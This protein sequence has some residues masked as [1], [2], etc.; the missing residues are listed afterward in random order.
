M[1]NEVMNGGRSVARGGLLSSA[2]CPLPTACRR[3]G[4]SIIELMVVVSIIGLLVGLIMSGIYAVKKNAERRE[5]GLTLE[6]MAIGMINLK[7]NCMFETVLG[8]YT[9]GRT[10]AADNKFQ[11]PRHDFLTGGIGAGSKLYILAGTSASG[12][13]R[14]VVAVAANEL[15]VDGAPFA[16]G[17]IN[18]EYYIMKAS[19]AG[20]PAVDIAKELEP[21]NPAWSA[22][23]TPHINGRRMTYFSCKASR[24]QP[25]G[26]TKIYTDPWGMPYIYRLSWLDLDNN[27]TNE[28]LLEEVVSSGQ[29]RELKPNNVGDFVKETSR[30]RVGG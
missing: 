24:I 14:N 19:G 11:D 15:T 13:A 26:A 1:G 3:S 9:S 17:E 7:R 23:Y 10:V 27:G 29:D 2:L 4:F 18:L 25:S 16:A 6:N 21:G 28:T 12:V 8:A 5:A 22:S 30:L 20:W